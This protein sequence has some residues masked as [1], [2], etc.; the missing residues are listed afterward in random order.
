M[1]V[2]TGAWESGDLFAALSLALTSCVVLAEWLHS[3]NIYGVA[4]TDQDIEGRKRVE[5]I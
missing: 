2:I 5:A 4:S 3:M 1:A